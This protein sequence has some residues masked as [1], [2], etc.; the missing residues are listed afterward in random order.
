MVRTLGAFFVGVIWLSLLGL[1]DEP[2]DKLI[3]QL[4][5]PLPEGRVDAAQKLARHG[6]DASI[7]TDA[8]ISALGD[9][10]SDMRLSAAYALGCV[11]TDSPRVLSALVPLLTDPDEHVRY[12]AQWSIAQIAKSLKSN[13]DEQAINELTTSLRQA[14]KEMRPREHQERHFIAVEL[15]LSRLEQ[16][17][18][19]KVITLPTF[20]P[21]EDAEEIARA[22]AMTDNMYQAMDAVGRFQFVRRLSNMDAYPDTIRRLVLERESRQADPSV[23]EY[24][25]QRWSGRA[26]ALLGEILHDRL[27]SGSLIEEDVT[28][29]TELAPATPSARELVLQIARNPTCSNNLR[30]AAFNALGRSP[31][32]ESEVIDGWLQ[33]IED[34][35]ADLAL[36][37]HALDA[38]SELGTRAF[39]AQPRLLALFP[40]TRDEAMLGSLARTLVAVAP[41]SAAVSATLVERLKST[42]VD[43]PLFL[44]L[45]DACRGMGPAAASCQAE[46]LRGLSHN[47]VYTRTKC[48]EALRQLGASDVS[49]T[50]AYVARL[51]DPNE[52]ISLKNIVAESLASLGAPGQ[53]ALANGFI[54]QSQAGKQSA[55]LDLLHAMA[56]V[57]GQSDVVGT[58]CLRV[59]TNAGLDEDLRIAAVTA[60]AAVRP[61]SPMAIQQLND[62]CGQGN[63]EQLRSAALL[64]LA[65]LDPAMATQHI[66]AF[67]DEGSILLQATAAYSRHL[68]GDSR[69][70]FDQLVKLIDGSE[71]D[72]ILSRCLADMGSITTPWLVEVAA[73]PQALPDAREICFTLICDQ[74]NPDW[75]KL[76][77][78]VEDP[79]VGSEFSIIAE[80]PVQSPEG[81]EAILD[82]LE[83]HRVRPATQ[84]RLIEMLFPDGLGAAADDQDWNGLTLQQPGARAALAA[85]SMAQAPEVAEPTKM[86]EIE[87][88]PTAPPAPVKRDPE[89]PKIEVPIADAS[90]RDKPEVVQVFYGTNRGRAVSGN[91]K[92]EVAV[93]V[94]ATTGGGMLAMLFC[95]VG[96]IRSGHRF[97]AVL[98]LLAMGLAAPFGYQA[99]LRYSGDALRPSIEYDGSYREQIEMGICEVS[100]PPGHKV[101]ELESPQM[102]TLQF[103]QELDKHVVLTQVTPLTKDYFFEN[104]KST[105]AN[106]G[107]NILVFIHGYNVSFEDA[108][109][110][111]AQ[112]SFDLKFAGA[113]VFYSWPSQANWYGYPT[114][115]ENIELSVG[116]I[117]EFL[118]DLAQKS[119]ADT[120]NLVAHSMGNVGLTEA[121][122]E[123]ELKS[124]EPMFNQVVLAAPDIDADIFKERLAPALA[125]K[126]RHMTLYTSQTDLALIASRYFNHG[127]RVGDSTDGVPLFDG[128]ETIDATSIDSSLIG[129][130]YY[131]SNVTVL[132]D[133]GNV[134]LN[135]P[136]STRDYLQTILST[137]QPHWTFDTDR[138]SKTTGGA[139]TR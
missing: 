74:S 60:L 51:A 81:I 125:G 137:P 28:L 4:E 7:A 77:P 78:L 41:A 95:L 66:E 55:M 65:H 13:Q 33:L 82:L 76:L 120:I 98:A 113:P 99:A 42:S 126:A 23:L 102:L 40:R 135:R 8:L 17:L 56:I 108:A 111:T 57:G 1:A 96:F 105:M 27:Q 9:R 29:L 115:R 84:S 26:R 58:E 2:I 52:E 10:Q 114:D 53:Q 134:L 131:G 64:S 109:R 14:I 123:I 133:L 31:D 91:D 63:S 112:M 49:V 54:V 136:A 45:V 116:Q 50:E 83:S 128:I 70:A 110:R 36:R 94:L 132:T 44:D 19:P 87:T 86:S 59:V 129:H 34:D 138:L 5:Q 37:S 80:G 88:P 124:P 117:K 38:M 106:K 72:D 69:R 48:V 90:L 68:V 30:Y 22:R 18:P 47:D 6:T 21:A 97:Y 118:V 107:K 75:A 3:R 104:L 43:S 15:A 130:S 85:R 11:Q 103:K 71:T 67:G 32:I 20:P 122:K 100:I 119:G 61:V 39:A 121:L 101:G 139:T 35:Q 127:Q 46:F 16:L 79:E 24:A 12:S 73:D 93:A 25:V 62:L 89:M 92:Q